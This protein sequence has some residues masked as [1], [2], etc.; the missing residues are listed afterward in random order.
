[1][2]GNALILA[3]LGKGFRGLPSADELIFSLMQKR[4]KVFIKISENL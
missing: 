3:D 4:W 2:S 1:M